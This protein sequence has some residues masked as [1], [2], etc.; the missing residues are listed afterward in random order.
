MNFISDPLNSV[1][2]EVIEISDLEE[3]G[4]EHLSLSDEVKKLRLMVE[5]Q[6]KTDL[7]FFRYVPKGTIHIV[8]E[9]REIVL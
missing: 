3:L 8:P 1:E 9:R 4:K 6:E 7:D 5:T 2:I